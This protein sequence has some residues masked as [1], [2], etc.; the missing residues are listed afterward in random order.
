MTPREHQV[1]DI[2]KAIWLANGR[3][4]SIREILS[5]DHTTSVSNMQ[6]IVARLESLGLIHKNGGIV[7]TCTSECSP[8]IFRKLQCDASRILEPG[9]SPEKQFALIMADFSMALSSMEHEAYMHLASIVEI[10][11]IDVA[12][13]L[14]RLLLPIAAL[15]TAYDINLHDLIENQGALSDEK[16]T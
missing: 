14:Y 11:R 8:D 12:R 13:N 10:R 2:I 1:Y 3:P 15:A 6:R 9:I 7:P 16:E 5:V 4:I